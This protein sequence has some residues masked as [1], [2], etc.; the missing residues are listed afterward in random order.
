MGSL[1]NSLAKGVEEELPA[2]SKA[3]SKQTYGVG[4]ETLKKFKKEFARATGRAPVR[5]EIETFGEFGLEKAI[6]AGLR[7]NR[8]VE[9]AT[10][11]R[12]RSAADVDMLGA[13]KTEAGEAAIEPGVASDKV[14]SDRLSAA[15][16]AAKA[17][18]EMGGGVP[19]KKANPLDA[20]STPKTEEELQLAEGRKRSVSDAL[21]EKMRTET[22]KLVSP[23]PAVAAVSAPE[24]VARAPRDA[25]PDASLSRSSDQELENLG[26]DPFAKA[27][28]SSKR[29]LTKAGVLAG[30]AGAA[31]MAF[32]PENEPAKKVSDKLEPEKKVEEPIDDTPRRTGSGGVSVTVKEELP[33]SARLAADP[34]FGYQPV[35]DRGANPFTPTVGKLDKELESVATYGALDQEQRKAIDVLREAS[36]DLKAT[37]A[38]A[39]QRVGTAEAIE[40]IGK[41]LAQLA[42]GIYGAR[43]G[44]KVDGG[45]FSLSDWSKSYERAMDEYR[46]GLGE[47]KQQFEASSDAVKGS[48]EER[49]RLESERRGLETQ[50]G[51]FAAQ[52]GAGNTK[53]I[54]EARQ[55]AAAEESRYRIAV[56][57]DQTAQARI[58]LQEKRA[59]R[60]A[61]ASADNTTEVSIRTTANSMFKD[62][63]KNYEKRESDYKEGLLA[64]E[65]AR[66]IDNPKQ[67]DAAIQSAIQKISPF[68]I[69]D[70]QKILRDAK[71]GDTFWG[72]T[73][74]L[75]AFIDKV[76]ILPTREAPSFEAVLRDTER[77]YRG[78]PAEPASTPTEKT[79]AS[80]G[81]QGP[82]VKQGDVYFKWNGSKYVPE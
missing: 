82:R 76:K 39:K 79:P 9:A 23:A 3:L 4:A 45:N 31:T 63:Q 61:G 70:S 42:V 10:G 22:G 25:D 47:A 50:A 75:E 59:D 62:E 74:T 81:P 66:D 29:A 58:D 34:K 20:P 19:L 5:E 65:M 6:K 77:V 41:G 11:Y 64:L 14:A 30:T 69:G 16:A 68:A 27:E 54:N 28:S 17:D 51:S 53:A 46:V 32:A 60:R 24:P 18:P 67:R 55:A 35:L 44:V 2:V 37:Y 56:L 36:A 78:E 13:T 49:R 38:E 12:P 57:Q 40:A 72:G 48:R 43:T 21:D 1:S 26:G 71:A 8:E 15:R 73:D 52:Q 80:T 33:L 7:N